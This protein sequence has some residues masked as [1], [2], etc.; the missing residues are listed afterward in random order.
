M[1]LCNYAAQKFEDF[2]KGDDHLVE[3]LFESTVLAKF[4]STHI[5][6]EIVAQSRHIMGTSFLK[7]NSITDKISKEIVFGVLQPMADIDTKKHFSDRY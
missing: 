2:R 4:Q 5:A 6:E 3:E 7:Q 1:Q